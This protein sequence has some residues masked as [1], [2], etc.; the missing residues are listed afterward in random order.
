M[1]TSWCKNCSCQLQKSLRVFSSLNTTQNSEFN[2]S[3]KTLGSLGDA[4]EDSRDKLHAFKVQQHET[5]I[6]SPKGGD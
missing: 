4:Q 5:H 1:A 3:S 6:P 2:I